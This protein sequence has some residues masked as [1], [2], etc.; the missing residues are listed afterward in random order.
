MDAPK[1]LE[2]EYIG[3]DSFSDGYAENESQVRNATGGSP[4]VSMNGRPGA[5]TANIFLLEDR[6]M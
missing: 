4:W 3:P 2:G 5:Q 6:R 1:A